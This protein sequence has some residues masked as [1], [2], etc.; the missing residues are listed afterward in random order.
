MRD[1]AISPTGRERPLALCTTMTLQATYCPLLLLGGTERLSAHG[2]GG[3][4]VLRRKQRSL[5]IVDSG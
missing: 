2:S 3:G 5:Y 4:G 1:M